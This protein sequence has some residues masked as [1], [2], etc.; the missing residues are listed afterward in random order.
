[1]RGEWD[2]I[3]SCVELC[4]PL[5]LHYDVVLSDLGVVL[6]VPLPPAGVG[7]LHVPP[8]VRREVVRPLNKGH[9]LKDDI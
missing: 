8:V 3:S 9:Q 6:D 2:S 4:T 7:V 1:M 5:I